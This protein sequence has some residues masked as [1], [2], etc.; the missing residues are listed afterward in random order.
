MSKIGRNDPCPCESGKKYKHCCINKEHPDMREDDLLRVS[1]YGSEAYA[2]AELDKFSRLFIETTADEKFEISKTG[3]G[4][5]VKDKV[6]PENIMSA[7]DYKTVELNDVQRQKLIKNN[8]QYEVLN[9]GTHNYFDGIAEG[10]YFIWER[11]DGSTVSM[12]KINKLYIRQILGN[13]SLNVNLFPQRGE[14]KSVDEFLQTGL[15][16]YT[17][18]NILDFTSRDGKLFFE[19]SQIFAILSIV[20]KESLS[21]DEM[22]SAVLKEYNVSFDIVIGK[23]IFILKIQGQGLKISVINEKVIDV[24]KFKGANEDQTT[25]RTEI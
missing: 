22:S 13:Y 10:G 17:E 23:P 2:K 20:D 9:I 11:A 18:M 14:I 1:D 15:S 19:D 5:I 7:R 16:I 24:T 3:Q 12:G 25:R 4:Y 8:L 6:P 21:I